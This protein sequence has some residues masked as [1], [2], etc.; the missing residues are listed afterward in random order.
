MS[1]RLPFLVTFAY[2]VNESHHAV[3]AQRRG[4]RQ[5]AGFP[6]GSLLVSVDNAQRANEIANA[7]GKIASNQPTSY[8]LDDLNNLIEE[9]RNSVSLD[10]E[11][12]VKV[13]HQMGREAVADY[14]KLPETPEP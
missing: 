5:R 10:D 9:W 1:H 14:G 4:E 6:Y 13:H 8:W 2:S 7:I 11:D 3:V 12:G